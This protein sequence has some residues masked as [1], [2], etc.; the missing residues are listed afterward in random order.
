MKDKSKICI[1]ISIIIAV[2]NALTSSVYAYYSGYFELGFSIV[3][4][5]FYIDTNVI[6]N[7]TVDNSNDVINVAVNN[8][9][10]ASSYVRVQL[11]CP[12]S[13]SYTISGDSWEQGEDGYIYYNKPIACEE[14]TS[15]I[16]ITIDASE[17]IM[18]SFNIVVVSE[19]TITFYD[20]E[21]TPYCDWER[22]LE[23]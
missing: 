23:I 11:F 13:V 1:F 10:T 22:A 6:Q 21:G 19:S 18:D 4:Y 12:E 17:T 5:D 15:N 8:N 3:Y 9:G 2:M 20:G 7:I 16:V 14:T